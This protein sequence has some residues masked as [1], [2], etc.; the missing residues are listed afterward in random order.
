MNRLIS[1]NRVFTTKLTKNIFSKRSFSLSNEERQEFYASY[2]PN[3]I[4]EMLRI[5]FF[6]EFKLNE[7]KIEK[8]VVLHGCKCDVIL[9]LDGKTV[10]Y[11]VNRPYDNPMEI[12]NRD[13]HLESHKVE[14]VR[15]DT[16][17]F[18]DRLIEAMEKI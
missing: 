8:K 14:V 15:P 18:D 9:R 4:D 6:T 12:K 17:M 7:A 16:S 3:K 11:Q 5:Q 1:F 2:I 10:N 13:A